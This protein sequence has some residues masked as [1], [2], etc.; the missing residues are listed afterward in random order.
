[1]VLSRSEIASR[2]DADACIAAVESAFRLCGSPSAIG[3]EVLGLHGEGGGFHVKAGGLV[4]G[5]TYAAFKINANFPG[6]PARHGLPTIQGVVALFDAT[7]GALLALMDSGEITALRTAAATALAARHLARPESSTLGI[8]GC[9]RQGRAHVRFLGRVLP[10]R[11]VLAVD[12]DDATAARFANDI[13]DECRVAVEPLASVGAAASASDVIVCCTTATGPVLRRADVRPGTFVAGVGAD[14]PEK[15]E[16]DGHLFAD[17]RVV[18]DILAQCLAMGDLRHAVAEGRIAAD[19]VHG[20][21][22]DVVT[23]RRPGR[24]S[25]E[26]ITVFDSTGMALQDVAA[27]AAVYEVAGLEPEVPRAS[28]GA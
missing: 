13:R 20:E 24:M 2:L 26:E 14:N 18:V 9:G 19:A 15:R 5:R 8:V 3:P 28:F 16:L 12:I 25:A 17:A 23:G 6:N 22:S 21:L 1:L 10:I 4:L 7:N 11:R 27:A